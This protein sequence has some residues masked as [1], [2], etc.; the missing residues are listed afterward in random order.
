MQIRVAAG[1]MTTRVWISK[2]RQEWPIRKPSS[3]Q[4][5][6]EMRPEPIPAGDIGWPL[7]ISIRQQREMLLWSLFLAHSTRVQLFLLNH[8]LQSGVSRQSNARDGAYGTDGPKQKLSP[9]KVGSPDGSRTVFA[10]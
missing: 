10:A 8:R 9:R 4:T 2:L 5:Y 6:G 7:A 3:S 1:G